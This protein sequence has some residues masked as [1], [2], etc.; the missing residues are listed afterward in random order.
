MK[1]ILLNEWRIVSRNRWFLFL[2]I[3][4]AAMLA[5][6]SYLGIKE[7]KSLSNLEQEASAHI[8]E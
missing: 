2:G 5:L 3:S 8:R 1:T 6:S 4:L 7:T